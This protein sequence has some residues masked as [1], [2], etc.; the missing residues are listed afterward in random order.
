MK[1]L[2][3]SLTISLLALSRIFAQGDLIPP[4]PPGPTMK[5]L[6]QLEARIPI[7]QPGSFPIVI[8][9]PGS[10]YLTGNIAVS[11]FA[12]V[13]QNNTVAPGILVTGTDNRLEGNHV[14]RNVRGFDLAAAGNLIIKN[15]ASGNGLNYEIAA[16]NAVGVIVS[17][18]ASVA[19]SGSRGAGVGSTDPRA[20]I[21]F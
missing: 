17:A 18:P 20:N 19:I 2:L 14:T 16:C 21:S 9:Q 7:S 5:T 3:L 13:R 1:A 8:S 10:Y 11:N 6:D 12:V 15:S 4:G